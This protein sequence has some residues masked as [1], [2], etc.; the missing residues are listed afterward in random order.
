[1][2][3]KLSARLRIATRLPV[4][5]DFSRASLSNLNIAPQTFSKSMGE[6]A[7]NGFLTKTKINRVIYYKITKAQ[8]EEL[9]E[10]LSKPIEDRKTI[11]DQL[12]DK[13]MR[14]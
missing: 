2:M 6:F 7:L 14:A 9:I 5:K 8:K 10:M 3:K 4:D 13:F 12:H 1:M 11:V